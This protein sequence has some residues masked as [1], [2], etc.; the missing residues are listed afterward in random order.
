[1]VVPEFLLELS[2]GYFPS[3]FSKLVLLILCKLQ[4]SSN[5]RGQR[6]GKLILKR[7]IFLFEHL[8]FLSY[9]LATGISVESSYYGP[10]IAKLS[11]GYCSPEIDFS[12]QTA[13]GFLIFFHPSSSL[14][15]LWKVWL[16]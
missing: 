14:V 15:P 2:S 3:T 13:I 8:I 1:M 9:F 11:F 5:V 4:A 10:T 6:T 16:K 7:K 12:H